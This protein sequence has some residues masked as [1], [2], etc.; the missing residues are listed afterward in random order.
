MYSSVKSK[1]PCIFLNFRAKPA[2]PG[3]FLRF[4]KKLDPLENRAFLT[5]EPAQAE[6]GVF[7][8]EFVLTNTI[9]NLLLVRPDQ[10]NL[11][12]ST[13]RNRR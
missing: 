10:R 9:L 7:F 1:H 8:S 3:V 2:I 13:W 6:W 11:T 4:P 5:S 12:L